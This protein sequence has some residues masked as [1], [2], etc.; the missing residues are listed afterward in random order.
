[1]ALINV[2][3]EN[4]KKEV[5]ES[6]LPVLLDFWA[7]WCGPCKRIAPIVEELA[8][9][10]NQKV[11]FGKI[12]IDDDQKVASQYGIMSIP[13]LVMFK[14]GKIMHQVVGAL[15]KADLKRAIEENLL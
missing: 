4:F 1:M 5:I 7:P 6:D 8:G 2:T 12:N 11:K 15:S 3:D 13:T 10:Y 9:E 14:Q